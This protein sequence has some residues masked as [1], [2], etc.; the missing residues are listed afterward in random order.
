MNNKKVI[1]VMPKKSIAQKRELES[2]RDILKNFPNGAS[3]EEIERETASLGLKW[4]RRTLQR[5][6]SL[7]SQHKKIV[8]KGQSRAMRYYLAD[9]ISESKKITTD[10]VYLIPLS[11]SAQNVLELVKRPLQKREPVSYHR[12]FLES[13]QPNKD[14]YLTSAQM[15]KLSQIGQ[16]KTPIQPIGT[17]SKDIL[18]RLL[19]D[20]SWNSSRLEGNTYSL[21]ETQRL[22]EFNELADGKKASEAQMILNHKEAIRFLIQ[23]NGNIEFNR[24][25]ILN[26]HALLSNNLL[27]SSASGTLR[28]RIVEIRA[29]SY[30]PLSIPQMIFEL[31]DL[32]LKK[33]NQIKNPY[34]QS[35]F[36]MLHLPYLQPFLDV[37]KRVSRLAANIPF[38]KNQL[39]P[40]SFVHVPQEIYVQSLLG[41]YEM[42]RIFLLRDVF[43]WAYEHSAK[44]YTV[45]S[46]VI[47]N[48]KPDILR[49][50]YHR[51]I[52][53]LISSLVCQTLKPKKALVKIKLESKKLPKRDQTRF[54]EVV[55]SE[56]LS[57]HEGNFARYNIQPL[58]FEYWKKIWS[59]KS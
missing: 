24:Y 33:V 12:S 32:I 59:K 14:S 52:I 50:R 57:L 41:V 34:E 7:L 53:L 20:F 49:L 37:N 40:L 9:L 21:L 15:K 28:N 1:S 8:I 46:D 11:R 2:I 56:L 19:I 47:D 18:D 4:T 48:E 54:V 30:K 44:Q 35:F 55:E 43:L 3:I 5:R 23:S 51:K 25:T 38:I 58:E 26:L 42:R 6:L 16:I 27:R 29:S 45:L 17:Y 39:A 10:E 13:Y 22:L 31:F 36:I